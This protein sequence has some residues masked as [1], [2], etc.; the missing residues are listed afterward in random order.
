LMFED[1]KAGK[2]PAIKKKLE[3]EKVEEANSGA[4]S[5][6]AI[7]LAEK[8]V[9]AILQDLPSEKPDFAVEESKAEVP[10]A[11]ITATETPAATLPLAKTAVVS[12]TIGSLPAETSTQ[13][14]DIIEVPDDED[15]P[16]PGELSVETEST[17]AAE[18]KHDSDDGTETD[19]SESGKQTA[20]KADSHAG[21]ET[22]KMKAATTDLAP[23]PLTAAPPVSGNATIQ[24]VDTPPAVPPVAPSP[25]K[26]VPD[27]PAAAEAV[28]PPAVDTAPVAAPNALGVAVSPA[29]TIPVVNMDVVVPPVVVPTIDPSP[30][31]IPATPS[32][33]DPL[34]APVLPKPVATTAPTAVVIPDLDTPMEDVSAGKPDGEEVTNEEPVTQPS[35]SKKRKLDADQ[36][37]AAAPSKQTRTIELRNPVSGKVQKVFLSATEASEATNITRYKIIK[38]CQ[39][40][41]GLV[42][43]RFFRYQRATTEEESDDQGPTGTKGGGDEPMP[44]ESTSKTMEEGATKI[45]PSASGSRTSASSKEISSLPKPTIQHA[46]LFSGHSKQ[47]ARS[48]PMASGRS[49]SVKLGSKKSIPAPPLRDPLPYKLPPPFDLSSLRA[50]RKKTNPAKRPKRIIELVELRTNKVFVCFRGA[51]DVCRALNL[52]RKDVTKACDTEE[53]ATDNVSFGGGTFTLRYGKEGRI[54]A[55]IYGDHREDYVKK[56]KTESQKEVAKRFKKVYA[57][58]KS[59]GTLGQLPDFLSSVDKSIPEPGAPANMAGSTVHTTTTAAAARADFG[60]LIDQGDI[61]EDKVDV[62][63]ATAGLD[64]IGLCIVCQSAPPNVVFEPCFHAVLCSSC[65]EFACRSFCPI[66][67]TSIQSRVQPKTAT[68]VRPRIF[69]AYSFM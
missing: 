9:D 37:V 46:L 44:D 69:S 19:D 61:S 49:P 13:V 62:I 41:G 28:P 47:K 68:L 2:L 43:G 3:S 33:P 8:T 20:K 23:D 48:L 4:A 51:T 65:A 12:E 27:A 54:E 52:D 26:P 66:C 16:P 34:A 1:E 25:P 6:D 53:K 21:D 55:Y 50:V 57:V 14:R 36:I 24:A 15:V 29:D 31:A 32:V 42:G 64:A 38:A 56:G 45:P 67:Q 63:S 11:P 30:A 35:D 10:T 40:G 22:E 7:E 18:R 39:D 60:E 5:E 59:A 17:P 58:E